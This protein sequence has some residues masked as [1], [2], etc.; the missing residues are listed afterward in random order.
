MGKTS[1]SKVVVLTWPFGPGNKTKEQKRTHRIYKI[2]TPTHA[3]KL[4][5]GNGQRPGEARLSSTPL[6]LKEAT[7]IVRV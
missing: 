5:A 2:A 6:A 1:C 7:Q 3:D 4:F